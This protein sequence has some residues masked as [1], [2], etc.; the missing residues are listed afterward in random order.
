M[1]DWRK[2]GER[3]NPS[4]LPVLLYVSRNPWNFLFTYSNVL[5]V[6]LIDFP[7]F[8]LSS[9]PIVCV[10][11]HMADL[12]R[13]SGE[14]LP[15]PFIYL[16][17]FYNR[18]NRQFLENSLGSEYYESVLWM[19]GESFVFRPQ[20]RTWQSAIRDTLLEIGVHP[21]NGFTLEH[22]VGTKICRSS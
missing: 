3:D 1:R 12:F 19:D 22:K 8:C 14:M 2:S 10:T 21:F 20:L 13:C 11:V 9:S 18:A 7:V 15:F 17:D 6:Y 16:C 4:L 5:H